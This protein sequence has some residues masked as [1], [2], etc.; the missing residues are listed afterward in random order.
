M[1]TYAIGDIQGCFD[2]FEKLMALL[3][4]DRKIDQLWLVGDLVNRGPQSLETLRYVRELGSS[5]AVVLGNHDLHLLAVAEGLAKPRSDDTLGEVLAASDRDSLLEWLRHRPMIHRDGQHVLVHAGLLPQWSV[6]KAVELAAEVE[7]A[8]RGPRFRDFL[9][10]LYG[11][12][13]DRWADNLHGMDR[14][15]VVV[16]ALTRLRFCTPNG[17]MEFASKGEIRDAP[18]GYLPW[19]E[20]PGRQSAD[21]TIVCGHWSALGLRLDEGLLAID[22]GCVWG[23]KLSA[24]SLDDGRLFQVDCR[25]GQGTAE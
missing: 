25:T 19:F 12:K 9:A 10:A 3:N 24:V 8:L 5:A 1:T 21:A 22:S 18:A 7:Q 20:V 14:L 13:P 6:G 11:S 16:N 4:F 2:E 15:R 17:V 23:G